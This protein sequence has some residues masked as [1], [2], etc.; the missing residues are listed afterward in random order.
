MPSLGN[1][2]TLI[3]PRHRMN[4]LS[5]CLNLP[6]KCHITVIYVYFSVIINTLR[7]CLY[8]CNNLSQMVPIYLKREL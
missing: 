3:C 5:A 7:Y 4:C 8:K 2:R 1:H 6:Y